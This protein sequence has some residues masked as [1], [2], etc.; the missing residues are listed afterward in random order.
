MIDQAPLHADAG[1]LAELDRQWAEIEAGAPTVPH[2][3]VARWLETWG[4][5]DFKPW[6][7][8]PRSVTRGEPSA[9]QLDR[10]G[11]SQIEAKALH[12]LKRKLRSFL[13]N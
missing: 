6:A 3:R 11:I 9:R 13:D 1:D 7:L 2:D 8:P 12:K 5:A 4:T 10:R